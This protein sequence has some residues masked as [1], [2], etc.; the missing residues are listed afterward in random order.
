MTHMIIRQVR[1]GLFTLV[2]YLQNCLYHTVQCNICFF[3]LKDIKGFPNLR[4]LYSLLSA[5]IFSLLYLYQRQFLHLNLNLKYNW[6]KVIHKMYVPVLVFFFFFPYRVS[7]DDT[8][9][10]TIYI[11]LTSLWNVSQ[12]KQIT[13]SSQESWNVSIN[14]FTLQ[15]SLSN[16]FF[17]ALPET[18]RIA[19]ETTL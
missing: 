15:P 3:F 13:S 7:N 17:Y 1:Q 14:N 18:M 16:P 12:L 9:I 8:S 2:W 6:A 11:T 19:I 5:Y 10:T 4:D